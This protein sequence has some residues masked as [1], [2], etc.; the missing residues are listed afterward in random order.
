MESDTSQLQTG[1]DSVR[2]AITLRPMTTSAWEKHW[3]HAHFVDTPLSLHMLDGW[4]CF[5]YVFTFT[6]L[7]CQ[8]NT[9]LRCNILPSIK[10]ITLFQ[11]VSFCSTSSLT[12]RTIHSFCLH[13]VC[14]N[15]VAWFVPKH[16]KEMSSFLR[17]NI[18]RYC[19]FHKVTYFSLLILSFRFIHSL[20][21]GQSNIG[22]SIHSERKNGFLVP[23]C[24]IPLSFAAWWK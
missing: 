12:Y 20:S 7:F 15:V 2:S 6:A 16:T 21:H 17:N 4:S 13:L 18:Q 10:F 1:T 3:T 22:S 5:N 11:L 23:I 14:Q 9:T 8:R 19:V 24:V